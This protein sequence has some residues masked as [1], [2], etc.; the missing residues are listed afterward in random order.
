[1]NRRCYWCDRNEARSRLDK[2][3]T[4]SNCAK[5]FNLQLPTI[6]EPV[7]VPVDIPTNI[8]DTPGFRHWINPYGATED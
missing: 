6:N 1:V 7:I 5:Q 4:C 8:E 3:P 2:I